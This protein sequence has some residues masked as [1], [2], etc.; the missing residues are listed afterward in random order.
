M[1]NKSFFATILLAAAL[2]LF[3]QPALALEV[4]YPE[5]PGVAII[6]PSSSIEVY[7][8]YFFALA[9]ILSGVVGIFSIVAAGF[10]ILLSG[11]NPSV[12]SAAREKIFNA[13]FGIVLLMFSVVLLRSV[14]P[15]LVNPNEI[16]VSVGSGVYLVGNNGEVKTA[17]EAISDTTDPTIF[18]PTYN[19]IFYACRPP[20]KT[21][22]LDVF[23]KTDFGVDSN[24]RTIIIPCG[25]G[26]ETGADISA[27]P[28]VNLS[29]GG[30]DSSS[31]STST[32]SSTLL[33]FDWR[34]EDA[35]IYYY[36]KPGCQG[37]ASEIQKSNGQIPLFG[38]DSILNMK[39]QASSPSQPPQKETV[40]SI[41][42]VSGSDPY[43]RY[44]VILNKNGDGSGE[45]SAPITNPFPGSRC[46]DLATEKITDLDGN[47]FEP[48]YGHVINV[49]PDSSN[50]DQDVTLYSSNFFVKLM[51]SQIGLQY[52]IFPGYTGTA[53]YN[54][55]P[56]EFLR[57][58]CSLSTDPT[59][60]SNGGGLGQTFSQ[61]IPPY[62]CTPGDIRQ[63]CL[64]YVKPSGSFYTV[65][66]AKNDVDTNQD[67]IFEYTD[68]S[69]KVFGNGV[70]DLTNDSL[71]YNKRRLYRMDIIPKI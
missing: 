47:L 5:I 44:G 28:R 13:I 60:P 14:N 52:S 30:A 67:G 65:V 27:A 59:C 48:L 34:Y 39:K 43:K 1:K 66:Y 55:T 22:L 2:L 51:A 16:D 24:A 7:I 45:C 42:I 40:K 71:L 6:T 29:P 64:T 62:E 58:P 49:Y 38:G 36:L 11:S 63:T 17:P 12:A 69:C 32:S 8:A 46:V 23:A 41:R 50:N 53:G 20:G 18:D 68:R 57:P 19:E 25:G 37:L 9:V 61:S 4:N 15:E 56:D 33:S 3:S 35:G 31:S 21:L 70:G 10:Q 26:D 54:G